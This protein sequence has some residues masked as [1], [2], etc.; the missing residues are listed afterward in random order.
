MNKTK[1]I[2]LLLISILIFI[3]FVSGC[4]IVD[5]FKEEKPNTE[6]TLVWHLSS[7]NVTFW[8]PHL[9]NSSDVVNI[10][11]Q[12]FEGL[13]VLNEDGYELGVAESFTVSSNAEGVDNTVYTFKLRDDAKWSDDK[14]VTAYDFEYSFKR[15]CE[16]KGDISEVYQLYIK[17]A[18]KYINGTGSKDDIRVKALDKY[19][20]EI[21][22]N[23]PTPYFME[24][25]AMPQ[26]LP[27]REDIIE[28]AGEGWETNP[29]T[30]ISNGPFKL[31]SYEPGSHILLSKNNSYYNKNVKVSYVKCLINTQNKDI[32][33][34]YDNDEV[35]IMRIFPYGNIDEE[36]LLYSNYIGTSYIVLNTDK[37]PFDDVNIRKAFAY[38]IDS[39]YY[40]EEIYSDSMQAYGFIPSDIKLSD[41]TPIG[42]KRKDVDYL[43]NVSSEKARELLN[44]AGYND[45]FPQVKLTVDD[46]NYGNIFKSMLE[47]NLN[48]KV[49]LEVVTFEELI[50]KSNTGD[51]E[52][53]TNSWRADYNDSMTFLSNF[54]TNLNDNNFWYNQY[55]EDAIAN[56]A[57][58]AGIERDE[59]LIGAEEILIEELPAIPINHY[60]MCY[61]FNDKLLENLKCDVLGNLIFKDCI[62]LSD[63]IKVNDIEGLENDENRNIYRFDNRNRIEEIDKNGYFEDSAGYRFDKYIVSEHFELYYN[64]NNELNELYAS[65]SIKT[66]EEEYDRILSFLD[67]DEENMPVVKINMYDNYEALRQNIIKEQS[68]D[69]EDKSINV[70]GYAGNSNTFYYTW[71]YKNGKVGRL[72]EL[73]TTVL[74]EFVHNVTMALANE[75]RHDSWL[76]EGTAMY[77]AQH[78]DRQEP[79][80]DELLEQG[81]PEIYTLKVPSEDVYKY[82]YSMVEYIVETYGREKLV[83]L[84][85]EYG[86]IEKVLDISE[87]EFRDEWVEFLNDKIN[88]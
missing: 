83:E 62:L 34:M 51:F 61:R 44:I 55:F 66:L 15:A 21:E 37:K 25:L 78:K 33:L 10:A 54:S 64:S 52:M 16:Q 68:V 7:S 79:Y 46:E 84:L 87:S 26:F 80:Y 28:T 35:H 63:N 67:V 70:A 56:S 86:D 6:N 45:D 48:I 71:K 31:Y 9:S 65:N 1:V 39:K 40:C 29:K 75:K 18:D 73:D 49:K 85:R 3:T 23:E 38:A 69:Y 57:V 41:G 60:R 77:L 81:I 8:D 13:T 12:I 47:N 88:Y 17:G 20:L 36:S 74:H 53:I 30:C 11:R 24:I 82:G 76:M 50:D 32:N 42:E 14:D 59:Y 5:T 4:N 27:V 43:L 72:A 58:T 22:L 19:T 2:T